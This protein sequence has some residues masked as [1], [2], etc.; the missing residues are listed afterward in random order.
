MF[1]F[2]QMSNYDHYYRLLLA[3]TLIRLS[4]L[5]R[6]WLPASLLQLLI[7]GPEYFLF[8]NQRLHNERQDLTNELL[9]QEN[10]EKHLKWHFFHERPEKWKLLKLSINFESYQ[11]FLIILK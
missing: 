1:L 5:W 10:V 2:L 6:L 4:H 3:L 11:S 7:F 9:N 8:L